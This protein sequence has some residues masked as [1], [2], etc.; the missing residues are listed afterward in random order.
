MLGFEWDDNKNESNK[1]K[2]KI[3]FEEAITCFY[4]DYAIVIPDDEHSDD[5]ERFV[6]LGRSD[7]ERVLVVCHC[8]RNSYTSIRI[9]SARKATKTENNQYEGL[10]R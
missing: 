3:S 5:E 8:Y 4:D 7:L 1:L 10:K 6:L 2:H 9:I